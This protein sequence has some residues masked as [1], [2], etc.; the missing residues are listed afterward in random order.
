MPVFWLKLMAEISIIRPRS[1]QTAATDQ[2][3]TIPVFASKRLD[4]PCYFCPL[5]NRHHDTREQK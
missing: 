4:F 5:A 1:I 2:M 3:V